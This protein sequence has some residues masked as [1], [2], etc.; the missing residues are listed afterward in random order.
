M[1]IKK[2]IEIAAK[3]KQRKRGTHPLSGAE[4]RL[5]GSPLSKFVMIADGKCDGQRLHKIGNPGIGFN[6][7]Y[8]VVE[9]RSVN[10]KVQIDVKAV[11]RGRFCDF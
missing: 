1:I 3:A 8:L 2:Y 6:C 10:R 7:F 9:I 5:G 11:P 4:E